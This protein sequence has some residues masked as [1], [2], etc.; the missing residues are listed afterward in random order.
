MTNHAKFRARVGNRD[1]AGGVPVSMAARVRMADAML[2]PGAADKLQPF[3][4]P[5]K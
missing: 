2:K 5:R 4:R 1:G 3:A